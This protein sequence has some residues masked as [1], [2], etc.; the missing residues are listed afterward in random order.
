MHSRIIPLCLALT[1]DL[2]LVIVYLYLNAANVRQENDEL[3]RK[4]SSL[5]ATIN[6]SNESAEVYFRRAIELQQAGNQEGARA[7]YEYLISKFPNSS[8]ATEARIKID[9]LDNKIA[10]QHGGLGSALHSSAADEAKSETAE[11]IPI[12][13]ATLYAKAK[14]TGLTSG[15]RYRF[16]AEV[17]QDLAMIVS[18]GNGGILADNVAD[19]DDVKNYEEFLKNGGEWRLHTVIASLESDGRIHIH[20][21]E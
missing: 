13:F 9:N 14:A 2:S 18:G 12:E 3:Q 16:A 15:Q 17:S 11:V 1:A 21:I 4:I 6:A 20:K 7:A 5:Q 10:L 8:L 19:F